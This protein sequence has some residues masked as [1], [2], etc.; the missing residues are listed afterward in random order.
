MRRR[1]RW[2]SVAIGRSDGDCGSDSRQDID[3]IKDKL[4]GMV[5]LIKQ[6]RC[7]RSNIPNM[8]DAWS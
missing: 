5:V 7:Q 3:E 8:K 6:V 4:K 1:L 2:N